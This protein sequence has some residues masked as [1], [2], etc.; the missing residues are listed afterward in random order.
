MTELT[1]KLDV[2]V[3]TGRVTYFRFPDNGC[4]AML[5][6]FQAAAPVRPLFRTADQARAGAG[7]PT[8]DV[9]GK[10]RAWAS[11]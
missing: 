5:A 1:G 3:A 6:S 4:E 9:S 8:S 7:C 11:S 2:L 10:S